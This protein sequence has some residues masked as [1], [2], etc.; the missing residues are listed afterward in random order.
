MT[1]ASIVLRQYFERINDIE[2]F[3]DLFADD[4][5][6]EFPHSAHGR[7]PDTVRGKERYPFL[8]ADGSE[9]GIAVHIQ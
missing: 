7:P 9:Q 8:A 6:F 2:S 1:K 5:V 4:G 3:L